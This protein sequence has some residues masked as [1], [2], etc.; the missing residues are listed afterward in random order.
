VII[1]ITGARF[2]LLRAINFRNTR[3]LNRL[4]LYVFDLNFDLR[5]T[6]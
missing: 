5:S 4:E 1:A 2:V 6:R 3:R